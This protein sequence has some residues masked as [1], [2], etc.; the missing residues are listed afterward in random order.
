MST[1]LVLLWSSPCSVAE[2]DVLT[3]SGG[4]QFF[5]VDRLVGRWTSGMRGPRTWPKEA[6]LSNIQQKGK[7]LS[8]SGRAGRNW[9]CRSAFATARA[10]KETFLFF[11]VSASN[12]SILKSCRRF[13]PGKDLLLDAVSIHF[14][15]HWNPRR[16]KR[17]KTT[18]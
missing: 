13:L 15:V 1:L 3:R 11:F 6:G 14:R 18:C 4:V 12:L 7:R 16:Q 2:G 8:A 9:G 17:A 5:P 10:S